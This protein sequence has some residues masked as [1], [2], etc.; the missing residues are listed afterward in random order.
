VTQTLTPTPTPT[1]TA[2][3]SGTIAP[4]LL[5]KTGARAG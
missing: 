2:T 5:G 4:P 3:A 1:P